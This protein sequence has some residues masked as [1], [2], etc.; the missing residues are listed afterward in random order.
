MVPFSKLIFLSCDVNNNP[1]HASIGFYACFGG[2]AILFSF[3][4]S[5]YMRFYYLQIMSL[6]IMDWQFLFF[7]KLLP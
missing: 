7:Q 6:S 2:T 1:G 3:A 5:I 4:T